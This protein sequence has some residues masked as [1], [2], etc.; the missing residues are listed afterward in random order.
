VEATRLQ[1]CLLEKNAQPDHTIIDMSG[2]EFT[3]LIGLQDR[4]PKLPHLNL[5]NNLLKSLEMEVF[6]GL[7]FLNFLDISNNNL[8]NLQHITDVLNGLPSLEILVMVNATKSKETALPREYAFKVCKV[9]RNLLTVDGLKNPFGTLAL[10][11]PAQLKRIPTSMKLAETQPQPEI[12]ESAPGQ[13]LL[14][15]DEQE[16]RDRPQSTYMFD[17]ASIYKD[18]QVGQAS[19][20]ILYKPQAPSEAPAENNTLKYG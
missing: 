20:D 14:R 19:W 6:K 4:L 18:I 17:V 11:K 13:N 1:L 7:P 12:S 3:T 5:S 10:R 2:C 16:P 9:L 15:Y 8:P